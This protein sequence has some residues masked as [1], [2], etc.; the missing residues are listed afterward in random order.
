M[1]TPPRTR[2]SRRRA[3]FTERCPLGS[4]GGCTEKARVLM[5]DLDLR[6]ARFR[7]A[8]AHLREALQIAVRTDMLAIVDSVLGSRG[9]LCA[10]TGRHAD[11]VTIWAARAALFGYEEV[12]V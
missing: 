8:A 1:P 3:Q 12:T 2:H 4:E 6:A 9:Y 5:A 10:S 7:D 11:A